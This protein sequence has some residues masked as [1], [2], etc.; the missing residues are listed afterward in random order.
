VG[1]AGLLMAKGNDARAIAIAGS[2]WKLEKAKD[3][4]ADEVSNYT[5]TPKFSQ[6]VKELTSGRDTD[7]VFDCIGAAVG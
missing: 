4:G 1:S 5:T 3:L 6:R 2:D 7:V